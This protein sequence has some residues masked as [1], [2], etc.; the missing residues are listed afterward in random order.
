MLVFSCNLFPRGGRF[1][2]LHL[3]VIAY[4]T[5]LQTAVNELSLPG[6]TQTEMEKPDPR[7][8]LGDPRS[9]K[10]GRFFL[11]RGFEG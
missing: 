5:R 11:T 10:I 1:C 9:R 2:R 4:P 3:I 6:Q 7:S 8:G